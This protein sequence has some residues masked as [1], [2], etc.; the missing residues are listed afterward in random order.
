MI[1]SSIRLNTAAAAAAAILAG[2]AVAACTPQY[3]APVQVKATNPSVTYTY[4]T[5]PELIQANQSAAVFCSRYQSVPTT[6]RF[7]A[8][9]NGGRS[10]VF[11]CVPA[12]QPA[13]QVA[14]FNS[15]LSYTYRSDQE[16]LDGSR[17]AQAYC[18]NN[19]QQQT[20]TNIAVNANGTKTATFQC[21]PR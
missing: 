4:H 8:E 1:V 16:L 7:G 13:P 9:A 14:Q 21:S 2:L 6:V 3:T 11:D 20:V 5:D 18:M 15:N 19:G 17:N 10:V 12:G